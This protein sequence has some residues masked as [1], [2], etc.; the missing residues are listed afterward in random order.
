MHSTAAADRAA[1]TTEYSSALIF[2]KVGFFF[3]SNNMNDDGGMG[4]AGCR[5]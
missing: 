5:K 4:V 2:N 3:L 1:V